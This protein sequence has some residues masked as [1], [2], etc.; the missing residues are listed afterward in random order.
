MQWIDGV[1]GGSGSRWGKIRNVLGHWVLVAYNH[2]GNLYI[3][4]HTLSLSNYMIIK[5]KQ[6]WN[7]NQ[8]QPSYSF[9]AFTYVVRTL[10]CLSLLNGKYNILCTT[11]KVY[12]IYNLLIL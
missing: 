2:E 7:Q 10:A 5:A 8:K 9:T 12:G 11:K 6:S 3:Y 4:T 1:R